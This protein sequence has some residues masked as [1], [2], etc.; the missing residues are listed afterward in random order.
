L[1]KICDNRKIFK[2]MNLTA[3]LQQDRR[4]SIFKTFV[5]Q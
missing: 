1:K 5:Q 2:E 4:Y 3:A